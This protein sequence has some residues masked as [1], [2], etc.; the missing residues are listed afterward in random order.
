[1]AI[2]Q[3][4]IR[5]AGDR[6]MFFKEIAHL[7]KLRHERI[8][9]FLGSFE[10][11]ESVVIL[12][13][14][15]SGGSLWHLIFPGSGKIKRMLPFAQKVEMA[16]QIASGLAYLHDM[17][18]VH[19]DLKTLNI[20][21]DDRLNCKICDFGLMV[22]LDKTHMTVGSMEGTARYM[23]PEQFEST[24]RITDKTD[25]WALGCVLLELFCDVTPYA[26]CSTVQQICKELLIAKKYP[27]V[28]PDADPRARV[29]IRSCFYFQPKQRPSAE[30]LEEALAG[31]RADLH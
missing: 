6:D 19:R 4:K 25:V 8:V 21:L 17:N 3:C 20:I 13:E 26:Y 2:K 16:E 23:A 11:Q 12:M 29:L 15:M 30:S 27:Q 24:S 1:M 14:F 18:V 9:S 5:K 7:G 22:T 31:V 28:P 10:A